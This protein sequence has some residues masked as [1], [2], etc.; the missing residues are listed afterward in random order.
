MASINGTFRNDTINGTSQGDTITAAAGNDTVSG[1]GGNDFLFGQD[2]NDVLI[3][4][5]GN[6]TLT[7][8]T[9]NDTYF[10]SSTQGNDLVQDFFAGD[11]I[12]LVE[13]LTQEIRS[14]FGNSI[15]A[16]D[17]GV[18]NV[19]GDLVIDFGQISSN[20]NSPFDGSG[21]LILNNLG[22]NALTVGIDIV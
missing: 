14:V 15:E 20:F 5:F 18:R 11:R 2:N 7:G 8:G 19:N 10:Y 1:S 12:N 22:G 9:G 3:G 13:A 6:D 16:G 4:G 17:P 21:D